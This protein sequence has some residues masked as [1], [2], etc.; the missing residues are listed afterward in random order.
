MILQVD[1]QPVSNVDQL[2]K[3]VAKQR[4]DD[5]KRPVVL[6]VQRGQQTLYVALEPQD[7]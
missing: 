1:R 7:K 2:V 5:A 3:A 4:K 6:L